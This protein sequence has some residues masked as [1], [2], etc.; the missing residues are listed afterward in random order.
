MD[1]F[2]LLG[3]LS[4]T[5]ICAAFYFI[6]SPLSAFVGVC[7][8]IAVAS[9][10][11]GAQLLRASVA[12]GSVLALGLL[13]YSFGLLIVRV[14]LRRSVSLQMLASFIDDPANGNV[15]DEIASRFRDAEGVG[16]VQRSS[17]TYHLTSLGNALTVVLGVLYR[18]TGVA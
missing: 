16:L 2:D 12:E 6:R 11:L 14:M 7:A 3:L 15:D 8:A 10:L 5:A 17:A 9:G 1:S 4:F 18:L 13:L